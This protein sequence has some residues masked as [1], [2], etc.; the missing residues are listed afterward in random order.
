M[1]EHAVIPNEVRYLKNGNGSQN[2]I[3]VSKASSGGPSPFGFALVRCAQGFGCFCMA[4][5]PALSL[6]KGSG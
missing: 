3:C 5:E 6:S 1:F 4:A 2:E